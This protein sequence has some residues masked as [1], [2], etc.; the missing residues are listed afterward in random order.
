MKVAR[1]GS[2]FGPLSSFP[3]LRCGASSAPNTYRGSTPEGAQAVAAGRPAVWKSSLLPRPRNTFVPS[4]RP[5]QRRCWRAAVWRRASLYRARVRGRDR[6]RPAGP[7][8]MW[9]S[10]RGCPIKGDALPGV[11]A[12]DAIASSA[13]TGSV[14]L[15]R[16]LHRAPPC[17]AR[18]IRSAHPLSSV[19]TSRTSPGR[20]LG[21]GPA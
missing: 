1:V 6:R 14:T 15:S 19:T 2:V 4:Y 11:G 21:C 20:R 18:V 17:A 13:G 5:I 7:S 3:C 16:H 9:W 10:E 8:P 12:H